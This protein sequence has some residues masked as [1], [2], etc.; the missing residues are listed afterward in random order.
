METNDPEGAIVTQ[1]IEGGS[2]VNTSP[3]PRMLVWGFSNDEELV[4]ELL[5]LCP[6]TR[7]IQSLREVRQAEW[8]VIVTDESLHES[9]QSYTST[10][11]VQPHLCVVHRSPFTDFTKTVEHVPG[12]TASISSKIGVISQEIRR[13]RN[14]P[15]RISVLIH[16]K[17]EP[18]LTQRKAHTIF[19]HRIAQSGNPRPAP[20]ITPF[21]TTADNH[22]LAGKYAR[23]DSSEAWLL[24]ADTPDF[25]LWVKA[26]LAEW[27]SLAP[28]RFPGVPD[29]S[30]QPEWFT[31]AE[32]E[33]AAELKNLEIE[34]SEY[35]TV[36]QKRED[37]L[38]D[39]LSTARQHADSYE[40]ALL[41]TQ[42]DELKGAVILA[43]QE[44]GF[45]VIDADQ[46]AEPDDHLEDLHVI[47][48]DAPN[49]IA[50][51]EVKGYTRGAKTE[52]LTQFLRF[53]LRYTARTGRNP[54][55]CWY[56]VNQFIKRDPK[57]R[58]R[59]LHGKDEDV[60]AFGAANGL[61]IDTVQ[62]F[63]LLQKVQKG[64]IPPKEARQ[65]LR[66][67]TGRFTL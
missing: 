27:H 48:P 47:D 58:Q 28:D 3:R 23:S 31:E 14:L 52:G 42:S 34:R 36:L 35:L 63:H 65:L 57:T 45:T 39:R 53:N 51:G 2:V 50:L 44:L 67:A 46:N 55:A 7:R 6:T 38:K 16:E 56:I 19:E 62:L 54:D 15:E 60:N 12:W 17:L 33:I 30:E 4:K 59:A 37:D 61:V 1:E 32:L 20:K 11:R 5:Q 22:A 25:P 13:M 9:S 10:V 49:W 40:R 21:I 24:P 64:S 29:W 8:D 26:A 66:G 41:T 18:V 43:L